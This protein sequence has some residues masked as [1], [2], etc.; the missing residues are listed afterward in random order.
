METEQWLEEALL[1]T[2]KSLHLI[3][4]GVLR[5]SIESCRD[6]GVSLES[7]ASTGSRMGLVDEARINELRNLLLEHVNNSH[8]EKTEPP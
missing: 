2:N 7:V 3:P 8:T 5:Q 4:E 6:Q 1:L